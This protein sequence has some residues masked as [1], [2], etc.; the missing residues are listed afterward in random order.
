MSPATSPEPSRQRTIALPWLLAW[1]LL[2][3]Y[4]SLFPFEGWRMSTG[5]SM[6]QWLALPWP[7]WRVRFDEIANLLA[8]VPLGALATVVLLRWGNGTVAAALWAVAI[9]A[10]G[11]YGIEV[12]QGFLPTRVPSLKDTAFNTVGAAIGASAAA[13][14]NHSG[15]LS[16]LHNVRVRWFDR[17]STVALTLLLLWP[18]GLLFPAPVPLGLGHGWPMFLQWLAALLHGTPMQAAMDA[19]LAAKEADLS[20]PS[21]TAPAL[22]LAIVSLGLLAP[23]LLAYTTTPYA[24]RRVALALGALLLGLAMSTLSVA[25][26]FGPE[27]AFAWVT[28]GVL[29]GLGFGVALAVCCLAV[30]P[31][32]AVWFGMLALVGLLMAVVKAP[33]DPYHAAFLS[34]WEQGQFVQFHGLAQWVGW[35]W[36]YAALII[37]LMRGVRQLV[38][39]G[40]AKAAER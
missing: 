6:L 31:K 14:L 25:L 2:I 9:A 16:Q 15:V 10:L 26:T 17:R 8:Y 1:S 22:E 33:P 28:S 36:P 18:V 27:H 40:D 34:T 35:L 13:V 4:A 39:R 21:S 32:A 19:W 24:G 3:I 23:C 20:A 5:A 11:S 37:L 29:T 7:T 12:T 38:G 30:P